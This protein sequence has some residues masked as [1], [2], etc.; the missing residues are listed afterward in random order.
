MSK[1]Q[2]LLDHSEKDKIIGKLV[3][4]ESP[5][6]VAQYLKLKFHGADEAHLRLTASMLTEFVEQYLSQYNYLAKTIADDKD[7][8][9]L[10]KQIAKSLLENKTWRERMAAYMDQEID[11]KKQIKQAALMIESRMEQVF[12][13]IQENPGGFKGD[14]IL[15]KYF[16]SWTN[17]LEKADKLINERPDQLIQHDITINMVEQHSFAFQEAIRAL[18]LELDPEISVRFMELLTEKFSGLKSPLPVTRPMDERRMEVAKL[19]P[20]QIEDEDGD[21][22]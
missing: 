1:F 8:S 11:L 19:L 10:D 3:N 13:K 5:K 18:L 7:N 9:K 16:D 4:G 6:E 22:I 20:P 17:V 21:A 14:Y 15:I 2:K 12:D